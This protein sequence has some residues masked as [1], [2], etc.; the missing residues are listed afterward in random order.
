LLPTTLAAWR[1]T[2]NDRIRED[3]PAQATAAAKPHEDGDTAGRATQEKIEM[4][5]K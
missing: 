4:P 2:V 1:I 3:F 5:I